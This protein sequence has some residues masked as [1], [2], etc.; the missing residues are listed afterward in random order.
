LNYCYTAQYFKI[1]SKYLKDFA[2]KE[3]IFEI[4]QM[5]NAWYTTIRFTDFTSIIRMQ[6]GKRIDDEPY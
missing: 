1:T 6:G 2:K 4:I 5:I 3:D